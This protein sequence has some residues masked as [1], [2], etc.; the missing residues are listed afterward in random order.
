[1]HYLQ[2]GYSA[3]W[4]A[5]LSGGQKV[6]SSNLAIPTIVCFFNPNSSHLFTNLLKRT[7][8]MQPH[9]CEFQKQLSRIKDKTGC[10]KKSSAPASV[11]FICCSSKKFISLILR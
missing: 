10:R 11:E 8:R 5:R 6:A 7:F 3:A 4:L 1:M 2:S 9:M